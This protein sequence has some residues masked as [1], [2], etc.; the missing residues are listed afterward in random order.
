MGSGV[1]GAGAAADGAGHGGVQG[2]PRFPWT[3]QSGGWYAEDSGGS[4]PY[5]VDARS[6][7]CAED[8]RRFGAWVALERNRGN[9]PPWTIPPCSNQSLRADSNR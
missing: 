4:T 9:R 3:G 2:S 1:G 8:V 7:W 6:A 5:A